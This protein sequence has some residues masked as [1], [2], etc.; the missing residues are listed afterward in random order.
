MSGKLKILLAEDEASMRCYI[1]TLMGPWDCD[2]AVEQTAERAI[3]RAATFQPDVA[4][5]GYCAPGMEGPALECGRRAASQDKRHVFSYLPV[6]DAVGRSGRGCLKFDSASRVS[7]RR[8]RRLDA[9]NA[10]PNLNSGSGY[11]NPTFMNCCP[12]RAAARRL[13]ESSL[14]GQFSAITRVQG[15]LTNV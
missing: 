4:L 7:R 5:I 2:L 10:A 6:L 3:R 12:S 8:D 1:Q 15:S 9:R 14:R 11:N 13:Q